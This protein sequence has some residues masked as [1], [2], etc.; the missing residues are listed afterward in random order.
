MKY[1]VSVN[2][3]PLPPAPECF[4]AAL[5]W[6]DTKLEDGTLE[7]LYGF[8]EGGGVAVANVD[9]HADLLELMAQYPLYGMV[10]WEVRPL[11]GFREGTDTIRAKLVEAQA[12]MGGG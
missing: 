4:D 12:A 2:P 5:D 6:L 9:S 1:L 7:S 3:G 11:L 10:T 8:L